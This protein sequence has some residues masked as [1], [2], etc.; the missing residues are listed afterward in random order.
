MNLMPITPLSL[1]WGKPD[2]LL[3]TPRLPSG[4]GFYSISP[5]KPPDSTDSEKMLLPIKFTL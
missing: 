2:P 1:V 3:L 5:I 4:P